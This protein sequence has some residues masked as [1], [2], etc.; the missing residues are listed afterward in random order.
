MWDE[1]CSRMNVEQV[2]FIFEAYGVPDKIPNEPECYIEYSQFQICGNDLVFV[3]KLWDC[4]YI[5]YI[6]IETGQVSCENMMNS[7][8]PDSLLRLVHMDKPLTS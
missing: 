1:E 5:D 7:Y 4:F 6:N 2:N 3:V 8:P